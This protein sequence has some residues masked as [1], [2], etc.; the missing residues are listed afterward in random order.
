MASGGISQWDG[1][2]STEI[3]SHISQVESYF[4]AKNVEDVPKQV[5]VLH[6]SLKGE[7]KTFFTKL[8]ADQKDTFEH[9]KAALIERFR[10]AKSAVQ[11]QQEL[12]CRRQKTGE[13][14]HQLRYAILDLVARA[15]PEVKAKEARAALVE[16]HFRKALRLEIRQ[17]LIWCLPDE[18]SLDDLVKKASQIER[19]DQSV[20]AIATDATT[21]DA[22]AA[23]SSLQDQL[24]SKLEELN[25][26]QQQLASTVAALQAQATTQNTRRRTQQPPIKCYKCGMVGHI[27]RDC[28]SKM[29]RNSLPG[30]PNQA[31][32]NGSC[33]RCN[34]WGHRASG[35]PAS[36]PGHSGNY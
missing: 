27:A 15:Y 33:F 22:K 13:T 30:A 18:A 8:T 9:A 6:L 36:F 35:C 12:A 1:S 32:F 24:W 20:N 21:A 14:A 31:P 3:D 16:A 29:P 23:Q 10:P 7:P 5:A 19:E 28:R 17:K 11:Y 34:Q 2:D 25:V 4:V 26:G